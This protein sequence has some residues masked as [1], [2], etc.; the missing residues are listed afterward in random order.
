MWSNIQPKLSCNLQNGHRVCCL[1]RNESL[2]CILAT[3]EIP[4]LPNNK[5]AIP[6]DVRFFMEMPQEALK[7]EPSIRQK[8]YPQ[9]GS[10]TLCESF[11]G[12]EI[13][14]SSCAAGCGSILQRVGD[15]G[16]RFRIRSLGFKI[17]CLGLLSWDFVS[18]ISGSFNRLGFT[19]ALKDPFFE[20]SLHR[21]FLG[22]RFQGICTLNA[23]SQAC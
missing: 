22:T 23:S 21:V 11:C 6:W 15:V 12:K 18:G 13:P 19:D 4:D 7:S 10:T 3:A 14:A 17:S 1:P 2:L 20:G 8:P 9:T 16:D 5:H